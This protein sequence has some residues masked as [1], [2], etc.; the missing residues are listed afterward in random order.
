MSQ[1]LCLIFLKDL[2]MVSYAKLCSQGPCDREHR[3][4]IKI[5][6]FFLM[7]WDGGR[8]GDHRLASSSLLKFLSLQFFF[9]CF[10]LFLRVSH[11]TCC[12]LCFL[13]VLGRP[14][15][16]PTSASPQ[17]S[18]CLYSLN[19]GIAD[20][21]HCTWLFHE[22]WGIR[23]QVLVFAQQTLDWMSRLPT[24]ILMDFLILF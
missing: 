1:H 22:C 2:T 11:W 17:G 19:T 18:S 15:P 6:I 20:A 7:D 8:S 4:M 14:Q 9:F 16:P 24:Q 21:E 12:F 23:N 5:G 13:T 10:G 3:A